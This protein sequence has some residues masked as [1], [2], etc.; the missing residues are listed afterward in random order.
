MTHFELVEAF[1]TANIPLNKLDNFKSNTYLKANIPNMGTLPSLQQL[2]MHYLPKV[3]EIYQTETKA[4]VL[5]ASSLA[6]VADEASD[7]QDCFVLHILFILPITEVSQ[8]HMEVLL[9]H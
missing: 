1:V 6:V 9:Q 2:R 3:F 7:I 5:Q 4:K 8:T